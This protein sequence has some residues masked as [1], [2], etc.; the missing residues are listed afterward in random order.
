MHRLT[1]QPARLFGAYML[2]LVGATLGIGSQVYLTYRLPE[3]LD[4]ARISS[5][6]EQGLITGTIFSVGILL[7]RV[8][9]ERFSGANAFLRILLGTALGAVGM[10]IA[11]F[12]FHV[13]FIN[14][15]PSGFLITLGCILIAFAY[16]LGGLIRFRWAGMLLSIGAILLAISGTWWIHA[17]LAAAITDWTPIFQYDYGWTPAQILFTSAIVAMWMGILGNLVRLTPQEA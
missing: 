7:A 1:I 11:M 5:S 12:V 15:P 10:N 14:T 3:F 13:L 6:L 9:V 17:G 16:A 2:A 8:I 4:A